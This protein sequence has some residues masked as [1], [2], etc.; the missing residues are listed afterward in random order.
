MNMKWLLEASSS[1]RFNAQNFEMRN[2]SRSVMVTIMR[3]ILQ[4][5]EYV[6]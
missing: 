1:E 4:G 6:I 3:D 2:H 5:K